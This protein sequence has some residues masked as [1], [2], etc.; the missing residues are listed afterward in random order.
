MLKTQRC[1]QL[2]V[3]I[4]LALASS[5]A[6]GQPGTTIP[7]CAC[8][9]TERCITGYLGKPKCTCYLTGPTIQKGNALPKFYITH[10]I[11]SPPGHLSVF[12]LTEGETLGATTT[13]KDAYQTSNSV[14]ASVSVGTIGTGGSISV[15]SDD[16][17]GNTSTFSTDVTVLQQAQWSVPGDIDAVD[18]ERDEIWFMMQPTLDIT[19]YPPGCISQN[20]TIQTMFDTVSTGVPYYLTVGQLQGSQPITTD[21]WD[22]LSY[23]G[24]TASDF[25][26]L[27]G[28][29][30]IANG[31]ALDTEPD[32]TNHRYEFYQSV[33]WEAPAFL[34][35]GGQPTVVCEDL[36]LKDTNTNTSEYETEY[37]YGMSLT[38]KASAG[39][40]VIFD[41]SL[42]DTSSFKFT[43]TNSNADSTALSSAADAKIC[44]P[45]AGYTGP[46]LIE[47]WFDKIYKT[48]A[49][50]IG[51]HE[52]R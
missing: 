49:F 29:D 19:I 2:L 52:V 10:V 21:E 3:A 4:G 40:S 13:T 46:S 42:S 41:A 37:S 14:T 6:R 18:H 11:Y 44:T 9:Y 1:Y 15:T 36:M 45:Y 17:Y 12:S 43:S 16:S 31:V 33:P 28:A 38:V 26:A 8:G 51:T 50:T 34:P 48:F 32:A 23:Y 27:L 35:D 39:F 25:P 22:T 7:P 5:A 20:Q 30:P 24:I 47:V